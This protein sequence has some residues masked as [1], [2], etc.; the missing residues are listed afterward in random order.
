GTGPRPRARAPGARARAPPAATGWPT[1]ARG[2]AAGAGDVD[3]IILAPPRP[4]TG[5]GRARLPTPLM[6]AAVRT[7]RTPGAAEASAASTERMFA[8][9]WGERTKAAKAVPAGSASLTK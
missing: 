6:S 9:A 8:L 7:A 1:W 2:S 4:A 3:R 5:R